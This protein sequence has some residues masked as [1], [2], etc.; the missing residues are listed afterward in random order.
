VT[1]WAAALDAAVA[2]AAVRGGSAAVHPVPVTATALAY[3]VGS[4]WSLRSTR[5]VW[6]RWPVACALTAA[7]WIAGQAAA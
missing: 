7:V 6:W 1:A 4:L 3:A 5:D 2:G